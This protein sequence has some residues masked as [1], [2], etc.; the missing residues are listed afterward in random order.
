MIEILQRIVEEVNSATDVES[1]LCHLVRR[2]RQALT[3]DVV[4][5]YLCS[6]GAQPQ[7]QLRASEG[8]NPDAVGRVALALDQG[9][10]GLV[11]QRAEPINLDYAP[12]HERYLF[13]EGTDEERFAAFLGVPIIHR[14]EVLGVLVAQQQ[15]RRQFSREH[16]AFVVTLAAQLAG[17]ISHAEASGEVVRPAQD[18]DRF[19][20][21]LPGSPGVVNGRAV[22]IFPR[23]E[24]DSVPNRRISDIDQEL[25]RFERA[26]ERVR[27]DLRR[28]KEDMKEVLPPEEQ[29]LFDAYLLMLEGDALVRA[30]ALGIRAGQWAPGA[31]RQTVDENC[32]V[33]AEME[34]PYLRERADDIRDLGRRILIHLLDAD[35]AAPDYPERTI[36]I[37]HEITASALAEVPQRR[38]VGVVSVQGSS[39]SHVA[40]LAR[41]LGVPAVMGATDLPVGQV[42]GREVILDGYQGRVYVE[43][44]GKLREELVRIA[45]EEEQMSASL[46][47]LCDQPALTTDGFIVPLYA[48]TGLLSEL[49]IGMACKTDGVGLY[50]T[51]I[52]FQI[53]E[54]FPSEDEQREI[55][56]RMMAQF[57]PHQPVV[58]R[59]LDVGGDK[60]LSYFPVKEDNPFLGWRGIRISLDH[61]DI[62]LTQV[63][64]MLRANIGLENLHILLPMITGIGELESAKSLIERACQ[65]LWE[66]GLR[67]KRPPIGVMIEVP[68]AVYQ[69]EALA[70]RVD[71]VSVG[72]N[73]LTQYLL[74]VDRN[75]E[76]VAKLYDSLHPAVIRALEQIVVGAHRFERPVSI[77][78]ELAG[79]PLGV[80]LLIGLGMDSLSMS[81]GSLPR[82]KWVVR[83]FSLEEMR[84]LSRT[85]LTLEEPQGIRNL[86]AQAL[87]EKG[88]GGLLRAGK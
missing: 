45:S 14:G 38:L 44:V 12:D 3:V 69:I 36:L 25:A 27:A 17:A 46:M 48:N 15:E 65:E 22:V 87:E 9:L 7:L 77:C 1:A 71:F 19:I 76:Q 88:L 37:G 13:I 41:A 47:K 10:V 35:A 60:P 42:D 61:P 55:Y 82:I 54:Y 23:A 51:E 43:P 40:I 68:S 75:N 58:A 74:A 20:A 62:F 79:D 78:G 52:P 81:I 26:V 30:T 29:A 5:I 64:A 59:T 53:R 56:R 85:A 80:I 84:G 6:V 21:G 31:L 4:S 63:R 50:R 73:D 72:T 34:D 83:S 28:L 39:S 86:L 66:E 16:V 11:A 8:L 49:R 67:F 24:L 70:Q 32:R 18:S 2:V 33:F 57:P